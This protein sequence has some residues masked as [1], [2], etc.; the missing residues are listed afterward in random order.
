[1]WE[2]RSVPGIKGTLDFISLNH[3]Y[4][5][6]VTILK[7]EWG[8]YNGERVALLTYDSGMDTET[9][10][11]GW[12]LKPSSLADS[13]KWI[14]KK[15][16]KKWNRDFFISEH[17]CADH[18][19][20][21]RHWFLRDSLIHLSNLSPDVRVTGYTHWSLMDNYEWAEGSKMKFGLFETNFETF[22]RK[23]RPSAGLY[24]EII[25]KNAEGR[26]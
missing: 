9:S 17:G 3:Y 22:E 20:V 23:A 14:H 25:R 2:W 6:Y 7:S 10:D 21:K 15:Y 24:A 11:F 8:N 26:R 19:D 13:I 18:T 16:N 5:L 4:I 12:G 1:M